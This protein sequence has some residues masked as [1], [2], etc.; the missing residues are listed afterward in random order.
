LLQYAAI[1]FLRGDMFCGGYHGGG[2][3]RC[4]ASAAAPAAGQC[5]L[6]KMAHRSGVVFLAL[7]NT[8]LPS[9]RVPSW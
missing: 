5:A 8:T 1:S 4:G 7:K 6:Q 3:V 2:L 9:C